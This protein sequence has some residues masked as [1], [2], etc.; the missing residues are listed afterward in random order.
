MWKQEHDTQ[1][2]FGELIHFYVSS[3]PLTDN[4]PEICFQEKT[5][6]KDAMDCPLILSN[7]VFCDGL[8]TYK[9]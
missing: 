9:N 4:I 7:Y 8:R 2:M 5:A 1:Y 3:S 6:E